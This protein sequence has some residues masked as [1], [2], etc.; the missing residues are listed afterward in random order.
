MEKERGAI[1]NRCPICQQADLIFQNT[2]ARNESDQG[3]GED[4]E[5]SRPYFMCADQEGCGLL[6]SVT[7]K[8]K[9]HAAERLRKVHKRLS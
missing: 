6:V 5:G 1:L 9:Y 4:G 7:G 2:N 3:T 8:D